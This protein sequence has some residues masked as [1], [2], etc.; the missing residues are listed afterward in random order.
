MNV[1]LFH[2]AAALNANTRWQELIAQNMAASSVPGFKKQELS[3]E[4]FHAGLM[5]AAAG[6]PAFTIPRPETATNFR[7]GDLKTTGV[8]TDVALEGAGF[9]AVEMPDG[10]TAYTRDGEFHL[11]A[12]GQLV[13]K[14]G[15]TVLGESGPIQLDLNNPIP[16]SISSS[17]EVSQG[18]DV[19]GKLR[20]TDFNDVS[21]LQTAGSGYF[22]ASHPNLRPQDALGTTLRQGF[23]EGANTSPAS[24]MVNLITA[25]RLYEANQRVI[26]LHDDRMG[27]AIAEMG[28]PS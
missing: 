12:S 25:M 20:V 5:S 19:K 15:N 16:I 11:N 22:L 28:N 26:Q 21:L 17:G 10:N 6:G 3:F 13:T 14:Q 27:K 2:A 9:L 24:E 1:S 8:K 23:L 18:A 4:S 7:Q